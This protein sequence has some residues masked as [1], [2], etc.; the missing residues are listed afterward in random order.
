MAG[1]KLFQRATCFAEAK[2]Q[3]LKPWAFT[4]DVVVGVVDDLLARFSAQRSYHLVPFPVLCFSLM[5]FPTNLVVRNS[6]GVSGSTNEAQA[7]FPSWSHSTLIG[8]SLR[9]SALCFLS[10]LHHEQFISS[11]SCVLI[12]CFI[13]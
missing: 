1:G 7:A 8:T 3:G 10:K 13:A 9:P 5:P 4:A 2:E 12:I 11:C 6:K